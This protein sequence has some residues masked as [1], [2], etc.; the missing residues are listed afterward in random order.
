MFG[1]DATQNVGIVPIP[2]QDID[3]A[4]VYSNWVSLSN[5]GHATV[6]IMVGDTAGDTFAVTLQEATDNAGTG[7]Q[8]LAYTAAKSTGQKLVINTVS[9]TFTVGETVTGGSSNLTAEVYEVS[10][11]YL[12]VRNLTGGT[13][14]T[15]GETISGG[16]SG[17]SA[18][19]DGTGQDEDNL[20]PLY[21]APSSTITVPAVTFKSYAIEV[22]AEM[23]TVADD[24]DHFRVCLADPGAATLAGGFILLTHPRRRGLPMP[25]AIGAG[26]VAATQS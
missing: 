14:W 2:P 12:L 4:A 16:T 24:Y 22:D 7:S 1:R 11:D 25:S 17:A 23:L 19:M 21:S 3:D 13:T 8:T 5:Y 10:K 26:K 15:D 6:Y 20:I 18:V 9:G